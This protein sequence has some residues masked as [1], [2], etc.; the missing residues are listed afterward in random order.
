MYG[1][2][3]PTLLKERSDVIPGPLKV[4]V[5]PPHLVVKPAL[6]VQKFDKLRVR[7]TPPEVEVT[8]LKVTPN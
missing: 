4:S 2:V 8:D 1:R 6:L 5:L 3:T 7:L